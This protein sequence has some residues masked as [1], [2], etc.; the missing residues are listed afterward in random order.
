[1]TAAVYRGRPLRRSKEPRCVAARVPRAIGLG[2][3][4]SASRASGPRCPCACHVV[5]RACCV[6]VS[7]LSV[8][9][10]SRVTVLVHS[11]MHTAGEPARGAITMR[12]QSS[13]R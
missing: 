7:I 10:P 12:F 9:T 1:M 5:S 13:A 11:S 2:S 4:R 3:D 8:L 6:V